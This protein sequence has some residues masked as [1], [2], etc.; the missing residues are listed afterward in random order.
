MN[1]KEVRSRHDES[2]LLSRKKQQMQ[3]TI[4]RLIKE[5]KESAAQRFVVD[6]EGD[7]E[8]PYPWTDRIH[9]LNPSRYV[10]QLSIMLLRMLC[11]YSR[12][13]TLRRL[14]VPGGITLIPIHTS[15]HLYF[16]VELSDQPRF[17]Q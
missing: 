7:P 3:K 11:N 16:G 12:T 9:A 14:T 10:N 13:S 5:M 4:L 17:Q 1:Y 8:L 6:E 15:S 2:R